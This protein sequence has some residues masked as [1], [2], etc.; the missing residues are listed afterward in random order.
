MPISNIRPSHA[1]II[2]LVA[3]LACCRSVLFRGFVLRLPFFLPQPKDLRASPPPP[4]SRA[5]ADSLFIISLL[6]SQTQLVEI[7]L[8]RQTYPRTAETLGAFLHDLGKSPVS[9]QDFSSIQVRSPLCSGLCAAR[10][11]RKT[12]VELV[13]SP[14]LFAQVCSSNSF[15]LLQQSLP[16]RIRF[17]WGLAVGTL[18]ASAVIIPLSESFD[19]PASKPSLN[20]VGRPSPPS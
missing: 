12:S 19:A 18:V 9:R 2:C 14:N 6:F 17:F 16:E 10:R 8:T 3:L 4:L 7:L 1:S 5:C 15:T 13:V 11:G 20:V